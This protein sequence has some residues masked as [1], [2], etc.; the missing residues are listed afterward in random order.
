[1]VWEETVATGKGSNAL[2]GTIW[3]PGTFGGRYFKYKPR[4]KIVTHLLWSDTDRNEGRLYSR[5]TGSKA[6]VKP[7]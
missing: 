1:M 3:R 6:G 7:K 2:F 5:H 4:I